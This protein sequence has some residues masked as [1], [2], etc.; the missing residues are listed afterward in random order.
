MV[1]RPGRIAVALLLV[2]CGGDAGE[3]ET[4]GTANPSSADPSTA[5]SSTADPTGDPSGDPTTGD[6]TTGD[7]DTT[8][9]P[10]ED[11][12]N[13]AKPGPVAQFGTPF[14]PS[15]ELYPGPSTIIPS[16][17]PQLVA[18][19]NPNGTIDVAWLDTLSPQI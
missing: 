14:D 8:G 2:G 3:S 12:P 5:D 6:P 19:A 15:T 7:Q 4:G 1:T 17:H 16:G 13:G 18:F 10:P 11:M 9:G